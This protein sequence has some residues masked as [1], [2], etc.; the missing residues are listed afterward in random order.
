M[1]MNRTSN[2]KL[3]FFLKFIALP[4]LVVKLLW[5]VSYYFLDLDLSPVSKHKSLRFNN[6][7]KLA[8]KILDTSKKPETTQVV[9]SGKKITDFKLKGTYVSGED[10]FVII[11]DGAETEFVYVG[12]EYQ[13]Y[14][15]LKVYENKGI[16]EKN[17]EK[18]EL[19]MYKEDTDFSSSSISTTPVKHSAK[20]V[21]SGNY[22]VPVDIRREDIDSYKTNPDK[23][24]NNIRINDFRTDDGLNFK[25]SYVRAG[26]IFSSIGLKPGDVITAINGEVPQS[27]GDVM[28]YYSDI[29]NLNELTLTIK[30]GEQE[31]DLEF[32]V[33]E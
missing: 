23:I 13:G 10:S 14:K 30:R 32:K 12:E 22:T 6:Q 1:F 21:A 28:K 20:I 31:M 29:D 15:L 9:E 18:Y 19:T 26:T 3:L 5:S 2:T 33:K 17:G 27:L 11:E 8:F 16:F 25:V 4:A 7:T 24:W